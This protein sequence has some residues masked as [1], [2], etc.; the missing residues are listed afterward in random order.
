MLIETNKKNLNLSTVTSA[1]YIL[2]QRLKNNFLTFFIYSSS[3]T[4][5][6]ICVEPW[7]FIFYDIADL[8][9]IL[10]LYY[11]IYCIRSLAMSVRYI[12]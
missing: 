5:N 12:L 7:I 2:R 4:C 3:G 8:L 11:Y 10:I 1:T 6:D 9:E